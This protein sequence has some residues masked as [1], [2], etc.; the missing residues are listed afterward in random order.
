MLEYATVV[1]TIC[2]AG[3]WI[4]ASSCRGVAREVYAERCD[5]DSNSRAATCW[6]VQQ[7]RGTR[8]HTRGSPLGTHSAHLERFA[9]QHHHSQ[10]ASA[11]RQGHERVIRH[12]GWQRHTKRSLQ[13]FQAHCQAASGCSSAKL[14]ARRHASEC[15][16]NCRI[17]ARR[18]PAKLADC[19]RCYRAAAAAMAHRCQLCKR[20]RQLLTSCNP[21]SRFLQHRMSAAAVVKHSTINHT[22]SQLLP[23]PK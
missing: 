18:S 17:C 1:Q 6:W 8:R 5:L 2:T 11:V 10:L 9:L 22:R 16:S 20:H 14:P 21:V 15:C 19:V 4:A 7:H 23:D 12:L 3:S 13:T